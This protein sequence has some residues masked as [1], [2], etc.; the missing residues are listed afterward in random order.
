VSPEPVVDSATGEVVAVEAA[1]T[2]THVQL[3]AE[4]RLVGLGPARRDRLI[5]G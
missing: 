3:E 1:T 2:I 5:C 4:A